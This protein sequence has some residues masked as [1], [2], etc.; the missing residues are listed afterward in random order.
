MIVTV[1][2]HHGTTAWFGEVL[3]VHENSSKLIS[4]V[5]CYPSRYVVGSCCFPSVHSAQCSP[6]ICCVLTVSSHWNKEY[7]SSQDRYWVLQTSLF[8]LVRKSCALDVLPHTSDICGL[9]E[10]ILYFLTMFCCS[11]GLVQLSFSSSMYHHIARFKNAVLCFNHSMISLV[12]QGYLLAR[13]TMFLG[14]LTAAF[15]FQ[16]QPL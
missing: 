11:C 9:P 1:F 5:F 7:I 2:I 16:E 15:S 12:I 14:T 8:S 13:V 6:D 10:E 3:N 4:T